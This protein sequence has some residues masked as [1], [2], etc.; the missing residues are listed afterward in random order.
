MRRY[1]LVRKHFN[2]L[3]NY[4]KLKNRN[5]T[6]MRIIEN[7]FEEARKQRLIDSKIT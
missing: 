1:L 3:K 7:Q 6:N 4:K 5:L 2:A